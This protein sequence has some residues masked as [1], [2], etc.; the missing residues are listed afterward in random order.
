MESLK[1]D[2]K[3]GV[4]FSEWKLIPEKGK[5]GILNF[6]SL[7]LSLSLWFSKI[8]SSYNLILIG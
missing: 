1:K 7:S 6:L 4:H 2:K 8:Q 3:K 5:W